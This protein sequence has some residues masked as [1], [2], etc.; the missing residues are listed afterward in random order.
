MR[1][2][3]ADE[4]LRAFSAEEWGTDVDFSS[5][6]IQRI[7]EDMPARNPRTG[8]WK[9]ERPNSV[10]NVKV[11]SVCGARGLMPSK[12]YKYCPNCGAE[13]VGTT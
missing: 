9:E 5:E 11:C 12:D 1:L 13:M 7:I 10:R 3:D 6:A 2:I 8:Y 4:V